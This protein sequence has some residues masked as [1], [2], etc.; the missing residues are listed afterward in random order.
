MGTF[1]AA[2]LLAAGCGALARGQDRRPGVP[3]V[4]YRVTD[5]DRA[6]QMNPVP[7]FVTPTTPPRYPYYP[8]SARYFDFIGSDYDPG[9]SRY[10]R[11]P[12]RA[13]DAARR[14]PE[15][16]DFSDEFAAIVAKFVAGQAAKN[17]G[18]FAVK[19][20]RGGYLFLKLKSIRPG[21]ITRISPTEIFGCVEFEGVREAGQR[22]DLDFYLS[23]EDWEWE[24][25]RLLI[26]KVNGQ[27]RFHYDSEHRIM[28]LEPGA[29]PEPARVPAPAAP[30]GLSAEVSFRDFSG[31]N[32]L[33]GDGKAELAVA[34]SNSG[35]GPAYAVRVVA[36]LQGDVPG[37]E[38][39]GEVAVGDIPAGG[40]ARV[41]IPMSGALELRSQKAR[42]RLSVNEGNGFDADPVIVEFRTRAVKPPRLELAEIKL[43]R[44]VVRAGEPTALSVRVR[45]A[46]AGTAEGVRAALELGSPEIFMS[47][48]AVAQLGRLA[49]GQSKSAEFEFFVKKRY[50]GEGWLPIYLALTEA[51]GRYGAPARGLELALGRGAPASRV[52]SVSASDEAELE[53]VDVPPRSRMRRDPKAYAVVVGIE[54]YRDIPAVEFAERDARAVYDYLTKAMGFDPRNVAFLADER[55]TR[56]DVETALGP[57]LK[58][59]AG[60]DSRIFVYYSGHGAPDP[61]TGDAYLVPYDGSPNYVRTKAIGLRDLYASLADL[62]ARDITVVMD[63]C[64]SGAG[65]RSFLARGARPLVN[66]KL[67]VPGGKLVV[68]SAAQGE[69]ISTYY[70]ETQHGLLTYFLLKGLRGEAD[71]DRNGRVTTAELFAF[72]RPAVE[73]EARKQ[74]VEQSP[75]IVPAL[76]SLG[77]KAGSVWLTLK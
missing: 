51:K 44:G 18:V 76:E 42:V 54:K 6:G 34:I 23:N 39:P 47:G 9:A 67:A 69:Q 7:R 72:A 31:E 27:A 57:W 75:T 3:S 52:F 8:P 77:E 33:S 65:G 30:A 63:S 66:V 24:V 37:L 62:P 38:L 60:P 17:Q 29:R 53:D 43:A 21:S 70:P 32:V 68:I 61:V 1:L 12:S 5:A 71:A 15:F 73:S 56:T 64:F 22:Y 25:S 19:D 28:A 46:G 16:V 14:S 26:H 2:A 4:H 10:S 45:T 55:A 20:D 11:E 41:A 40:K 50:Q 74:H 49:P 35:T 36:A 13:D 59:R 48:D 58:D